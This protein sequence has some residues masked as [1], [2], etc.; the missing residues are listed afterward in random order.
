MSSDSFRHWAVTRWWWS[1]TTEECRSD[2]TTPCSV[3]TCSGR[4]SQSPGRVVRIAHG[5]GNIRAEWGHEKAALRHP[6][7]L[8]PTGIADLV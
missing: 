4:L 5:V 8:R 6:V 3:R 2:G 1:G 7:V